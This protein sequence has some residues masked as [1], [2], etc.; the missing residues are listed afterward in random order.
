M[1][2]LDYIKVE[3]TDDVGTNNYTKI[4]TTIIQE[5]NLSSIIKGIHIYIDPSY[6]L[7]VAAGIIRPSRSAIHV[8]DIGNVLSQDGITTIS[9]GDETYLSDMLKLLWNRFGSENVSQPDRFT[10]TIN[11]VSVPAGFSDWI[12][13]DPTDN[14][15]KDLIYAIQIISPEGFK[16]RRE[17]YGTDKFYYV[18]SE[19]TLPEDITDTVVQDLFK[20][21]EMALQ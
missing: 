11:N 9:V 15:Y 21:M 14:L 13:I 19:N 2:G 3:S 10:V 1:A 8:S 20:K 17:N 7:F 16:V 18:S 4:A 5:H 12:V 6:P